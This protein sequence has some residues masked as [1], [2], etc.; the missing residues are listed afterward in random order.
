[1]NP[2]SP[3]FAAAEFLLAFLVMLVMSRLLSVR[4]PANRVSAIDGLRGY[5]GFAVFLHHGAIWFY[6]LRSGE[7]ALPPSWLYTHLGQ[8]GVALFFMT[9][10]PKNVF[11]AECLN[12]H[13]ENA[14]DKDGKSA[15]HAR[16]HA[17]NGATGRGRPEHCGSSALPGSGRLDALQLSQGTAPRQAPGC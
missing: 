7:W 11:L 14:N 9:L 5:L 1:M 17:R 10:P 15:I 16:I 2:V 12:S 4:F 6:Y 3:V 8:S 13:R